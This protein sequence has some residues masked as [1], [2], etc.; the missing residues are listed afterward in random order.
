MKQSSYTG[1]ESTATAL[2]Y[3]RSYTAKVAFINYT[4]CEQ[5]HEHSRRHLRRQSS[6][7]KRLRSWESRLNKVADGGGSRIQRG[8]S[9]QEP[10]FIIFYFCVFVTFCSSFLAV[11]WMQVFLREVLSQYLQFS[12]TC[13]PLCAFVYRADLH[14]TVPITGWWFFGVCSQ[15]SNPRD[16]GD[17]C[18]CVL[19]RQ[20]QWYGH[21]QEGFHTFT[22]VDVRVHNLYACRGPFKSVSL[23]V[24]ES[25]RRVIF[26]M[27]IVMT[28]FE[29]FCASTINWWVCR[30][31]LTPIPTRRRKEMQR[32]LSLLGAKA[33]QFV[34]VALLYRL[35]LYRVFQIY[36]WELLISKQFF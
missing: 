26:S 28:I 12:G 1:S 8:T 22:L 29:S 21:Q 5:Q 13:V 25:V 7:E 9:K 24:E 4:T 27:R 15:S 10:V 3:S 32:D 2:T 17:G 16:D 20:R 23:N 6:L 30:Q 19:Q 35:E 34:E 14:A 33:R 31:V 18:A 36:T 11:M